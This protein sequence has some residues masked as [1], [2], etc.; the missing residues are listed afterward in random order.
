KGE[1]SQQ[2]GYRNSTTVMYAIVNQDRISSMDSL[3]DAVSDNNS[4]NL[5]LDLHRLSF[6]LFPKVFPDTSLLHTVTLG[7]LGD[8]TSKQDFGIIPFRNLLR[9]LKQKGISFDDCIS[10]AGR[11]GL[12]PYRNMAYHDLSRDDYENAV[13]AADKDVEL[14][15]D[16]PVSLRAKGN[17]YQIAHER[18]FRRTGNESDDSL[19][20]ESEQLILRAINL[21][22]EN[23]MGHYELGWVQEAGGKFDDA[24]NSFKKAHELEPSEQIHLIARG[25]LLSNLG[26]HDEALIELEKARELGPNTPFDL[27][28]LGTTYAIAGQSENAHAAIDE[29]I[30]MAPKNAHAHEAKAYVHRIEGDYEKA[31]TESNEALR[32]L[33]KKVGGRGGML[34]DRAISY[35]LLGKKE[36]AKAD[37]DELLRLF[38]THLDSS[39]I[40]KSPK[41]KKAFEDISLVN[42]DQAILLGLAGRPDEAREFFERAIKLDPKNTAKYEEQMRMAL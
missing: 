31:I 24:L 3:L 21:D 13:L 17:L 2:P 5:G 4:Y 28:M 32:L 22:P 42:S 6:G 14:N 35:A 34:E 30:Q 10:G 1:V 19:L 25:N 36:E 15:P 20:M 27:M 8:L 11:F 39:L 40:D 16:N 29:A 33:P 37:V 18:G 38:P 23:S 26:R 9:A 41:N 12:H 7:L